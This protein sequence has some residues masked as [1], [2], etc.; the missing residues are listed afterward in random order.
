MMSFLCTDMGALLQNHRCLFSLPFQ[1]LVHRCLLLAPLPF[2]VD[3]VKKYL[4]YIVTILFKSPLHLALSFP[5][6]SSTS[7]PHTPSSAFFIL[8]MCSFPRHHIS[9]RAVSST[10]TTRAPHLA[11]RR[12][13]SLAPPRLVPWRRKG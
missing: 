3:F 5:L 1:T 4:Y 11:G 8:V 7:L 12:R 13:L 2:L 6:I 9:S 10:T